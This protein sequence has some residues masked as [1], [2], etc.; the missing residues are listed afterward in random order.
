V[1]AA[2]RVPGCP[3]S[4]VIPEALFLVKSTRKCVKSSLLK[5]RITP[6]R[7]L[8]GSPT[9]VSVLF[10]L[11]EAHGEA[12]VR[13][14]V[15]N[16][17]KR[18]EAPGAGTV[19][20]LE[21]PKK[22]LFPGHFGARTC[23]RFDFADQHVLARTLGVERVATRLC[24]DSAASTRLLALAKR[25]GAFRRLSGPRGRDVLV[26][27]FSRFHMGSDGFAVKAEAEGKG[28]GVCACSA[29]GRGE[30]RT[31]EVVA[32][33]V[34]ERLLTSPSLERGVPHRAALR[35]DEA[36]RPGARPWAHGRLARRTVRMSP[37]V[38]REHH[39]FRKNFQSTLRTGFRVR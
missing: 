2:Q 14:T 24:F 6:H 7:A 31:T 18:F 25:V 22:T 9:R 4:A 29:R 26:A 12:A 13:W 27:L 30:A 28:G 34:A 8:P 21:D 17:D 1:C 32:A 19:G 35:A 37:R 10:G 33:I 20:G 3:T 38:R 5:R 11:G 16:L 15:E 36:F 23:Y 39:P